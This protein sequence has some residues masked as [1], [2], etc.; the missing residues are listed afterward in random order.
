VHLV[1]VPNEISDQDFNTAKVIEFLASADV[2]LIAF[3]SLVV[4]S[5]SLSHGQIRR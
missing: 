3:A 4:V 5:D 1:D 2:S